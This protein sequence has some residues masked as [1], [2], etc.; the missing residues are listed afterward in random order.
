MGA[1]QQ[2]SQ[3]V[4]LPDGQ[5]E[6]CSVMRHGPGCRVELE[7][8]H[9]HLRF[10]AEL[11]HA[12]PQNRAH[13]EHQFPGRERLGDVIVRTD[14]QSQDPVILRPQ[15]RQH[16]DGD[17]HRLAEPAAHFHAVQ[18]GQHA[19][20]Q[21]EVRVP[22]RR[23]AQGREPVRSEVHLE[24][25]LHKVVTDHSGDGLFVFDEEYPPVSDC[26]LDRRRLGLVHSSSIGSTPGRGAALPPAVAIRRD[27]V[28]SAESWA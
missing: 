12:A 24:A 21:D 25:R 27:S 17:A 14:L 28:R 20:Q 1:A 18:A 8:G 5:R 22:L 7:P 10:G 23:E 2:E 9:L 26:G 11:L 16:N 19:V 4:E 6:R 3:Q 13:P 15:G